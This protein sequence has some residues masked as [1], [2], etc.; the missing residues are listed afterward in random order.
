M[1]DQCPICLEHLIENIGVAVPC[2]HCF[3]RDCF[4]RLKKDSEQRTDD[5][6]QRALLQRC[7]IC[8]KKVR[9]F[10]SLFLNFDPA[11]KKSVPPETSLRVQQL[12]GEKEELAERL[13]KLQALSSDQSEILCRLVPRHDHLEAR[14][15]EVKKERQLLKRQ[16]D[17]VEDEN[18]D[19]RF[20]CFDAEAKLQRTKAHR[21]SVES[22]LEE[23]VGENHDLHEIWDSLEQQLEVTKTKRKS[24]KSKL[25]QKLREK[26]QQLDTSQQEMEKTKKEKEAL[27][28]QLSRFC[29]QVSKLKSAKKKRRAK[30]K[31]RMQKVNLIA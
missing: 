21:S 25:M 31:H 3:H 26:C 13:N 28:A 16:L 23:A 10:H 15:A 6:L 9:K 17:M 12:Q 7:C 14:Y 19:L 29:L 4:E 24:C 20:S 22:K 8:K 11:D 5:I 18:W 2:G 30:S 27:Q 1:T